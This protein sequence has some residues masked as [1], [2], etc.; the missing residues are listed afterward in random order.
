MCVYDSAVPPFPLSG[1]MWRRWWFRPSAGW[2]S[3]RLMFAVCFC[4]A[5]QGALI[6]FAT[7]RAAVARGSVRQA[8][9]IV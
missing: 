9:L 6:N 8:R 4:R 2:V 7:F 3:V 5:P 1:D